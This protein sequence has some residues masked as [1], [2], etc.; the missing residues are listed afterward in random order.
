MKRNNLI[1]TSFLQALGVFIYILLVAGILSE[2][3]ELFGKANQFWTPVAILLLFV[4]SAA[5]TGL[6]VLG[7]PIILYLNGAK[8]DGIKLFGY[9]I[10]WLV[11][12]MAAVF[13]ILVALK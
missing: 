8:K 2:G 10:T 4:I 12:I 9:T 1:L 7:K 11:L 5:I 6:L 13:V 3:N